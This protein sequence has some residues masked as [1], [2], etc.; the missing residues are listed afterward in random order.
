MSVLQ[1]YDQKYR[2][3]SFVRRDGILQMALHSDGGPMQ[4]G[5]ALGSI[6]EQLGHAF[7]DVAHDIENRVY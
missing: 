7:F 1:D 5:A 2:N 3:I 4:W 6:H